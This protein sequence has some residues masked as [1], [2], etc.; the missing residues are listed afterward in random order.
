MKNIIAIHGAFSTPTIF[1]YLRG[2]LK[3][4]NWNFLDYSDIT[5]DVKSLVT[6]CINDFKDTK[7]QYH[8]VGHSMGGL[9]ALALAD[10]PF[11]K[12]VT[13]IAAP[14]GGLELSTLQSY[15]SRSSFLGEIRTY[16][17][18]MSSV[19]NQDYT[20][21]VQHVITTQGF[22]PWSYDESDG[23]VS[24]RSQRGWK[25]GKTHDISA[26]HSEVMLH[27]DTVSTLKNF[28]N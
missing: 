13:T 26:N 11:V 27:P 18:F 23:V 12:T 22:N 8:I 25:V 15:L 21:P 3:E 24:L 1:N 5:G 17:A 7:E 19:H 28:W 20:K 2:E 16:S 4:Y 14:L 10:Q 6:Q 9:I